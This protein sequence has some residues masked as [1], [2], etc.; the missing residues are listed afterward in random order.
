MR[1]S[2][3]ARARGAQASENAGVSSDGGW[4]SPQPDG[5][6]LPGEVRPPG[7]SR[8]LRRGREAQSMGMRRRFRS[9]SAWR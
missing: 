9:P 1:R 5:R 7:V 3:T 4:E 8:G 6:G 2:G